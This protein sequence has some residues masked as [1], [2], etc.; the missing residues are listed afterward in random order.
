MIENI[1]RDSRFA[2][3]HLSDGV[4]V[5][6]ANSYRQAFLTTPGRQALDFSMSYYLL[7]T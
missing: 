2:F 1:L 5:I 3:T 7:L 4:Q 6:V